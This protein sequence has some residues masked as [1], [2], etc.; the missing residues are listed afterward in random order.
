[1]SHGT[2]AIDVETASPFNDPGWDDFD[3]TAYFELVAI[4]LGY[5][6][7]PDGRLRRRY[8]FVV[9]DRTMTLPPLC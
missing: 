8:S 2:L 9:G 1:M 6:S 4:A 5:Q 3:D 7:E